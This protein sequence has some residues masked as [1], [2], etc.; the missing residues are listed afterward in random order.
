MV[1][2]NRVK[3]ELHGGF[4]DLAGEFLVAI[5]LCCVKMAFGDGNLNRGEPDCG[6][7][8]GAAVAMRRAS[9]LTGKLT[10][11]NPAMS[12]AMIRLVFLS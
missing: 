11:F 10:D 9:C 3:L 5:P 6:S 1:S 2:L 12:L 4:W 8:G 7:R